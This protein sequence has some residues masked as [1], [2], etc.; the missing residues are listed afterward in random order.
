MDKLPPPSQLEL[1]TGNVADKWK[2]FEQKLDLYLAAIEKNESADNIKNAIFL[3]CAGTE[4]LELFNTFVFG[5][6]EKTN[7]VVNFEAIKKKF[8]EYCAPQTNETYERYVFNSRIQKEQEPIAN[9]ITDVKLKAKT[10]N[11]ETKESGLVRDQIILGVRDHKLKERLLRVN[12]LDLPTC[13]TQCRAAEA[14]T[15]QMGMLNVKSR[16]DESRSVVAVDVIS[17]TRTQHPDNNNNYKNNNNNVSFDCTKCGERHTR[18]KCRAY[19]KTC[20]KCGGRNHFHEYCRTRN[21]ERNVE[22]KVTLTFLVTADACRC[23]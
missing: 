23:V 22:R 1:S 4:A 17:K 20:H 16:A 21:V 13:E 15:S 6:D 7:G 9:F 12:N 19:G 10:C 11:F 5:D 14:A 18:G 3:T 2:V 8:K